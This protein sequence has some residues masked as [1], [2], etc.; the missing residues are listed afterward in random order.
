[1]L[2]V[3]ASPDAVGYALLA[4]GIAASGAVAAVLWRGER[5][6]DR[7]RTLLAAGLLATVG[8]APFLAWRIV[9]DVRYTRRLDASTYDGAGPVQAFLQPY[10]LDRVPAL[11]PRGAT[12]AAVTGGAVPY[13]TARE[14]FP[15]LAHETLFPRISVSDPR[16]ADYVVAWGVDP[17]SVAPVRR[18]VVARRAAGAYPA[19]RVA[20]VRR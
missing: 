17:Q 6:R 13:P 15:S 9:E 1:M 2:G 19:L 20:E 18:V 3:P 14:A 5:D 16:R 7:V 12:Y 8:A 11:I 10:L 4:L